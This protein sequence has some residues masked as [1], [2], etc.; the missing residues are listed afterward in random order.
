MNLPNPRYIGSTGHACPCFMVC[1]R[2]LCLKLLRINSNKVDVHLASTCQPFKTCENRENDLILSSG[3]YEL[4]RIR[5][6]RD[7]GLLAMRLATPA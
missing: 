5:V 2:P 1:L 6:S 7:R 4:A 3:S